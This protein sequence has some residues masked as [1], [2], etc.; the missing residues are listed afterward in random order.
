MT[1]TVLR[2]R[3]S[4]QLTNEVTYVAPPARAPYGG[5]NLAIVNV[6]VVDFALNTPVADATVN[7]STG[8]SAPRSDTTDST[9][10]V[11]FAALTPNPSAADFY[12]LDGEHVG[13]RDI[14]GRPQPEHV[15]AC[16]AR[17]RPDLQHRDPRLP[18]R[19]DHR[20]R[21]GHRRLDLRGDGRGHALV[22]ARVRRPSATRAAR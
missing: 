7:L 9:G 16:L 11:T 17:S 18:A 8:P 6:Q 19:H 2:A 4:K 1:V 22:G 21:E 3:D 20:E 12:D 13:L 5:I 15:H 10:T 14:E